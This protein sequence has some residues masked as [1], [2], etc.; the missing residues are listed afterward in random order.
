MFTKGDI[1][2]WQ[3]E[4]GTVKAPDMYAGGVINRG[5][6]AKTDIRLAVQTKDMEHPVYRVRFEPHSKWLHGE[7][8]FEDANTW[9][10]RMTAF[11]SS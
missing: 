8:N 9:S 7:R 1:L 5:T 11:R 2:G 3:V 10:N 4:Y 6:Q